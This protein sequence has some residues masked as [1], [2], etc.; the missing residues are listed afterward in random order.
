MLN[1]LQGFLLE[2][3]AKSELLRIAFEEGDL[4]IGNFTKREIRQI[5]KQG[6]WSSETL[7]HNGSVPRKSTLHLKQYGRFVFKARLLQ[8]AIDWIAANI[9]GNFQ[10]KFQNRIDTYTLSVTIFQKIKM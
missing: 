1:I 2:P 10:F 6:E 7:G 3:E 5:V 9:F 4:I 8:S